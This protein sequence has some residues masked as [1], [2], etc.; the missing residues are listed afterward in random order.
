MDMPPEAVHIDLTNDQQDDV[1][2]TEGISAE[3]GE[4]E[5]FEHRQMKQSRRRSPKR[6]RHVI[7]SQDLEETEELEAVLQELEVCHQLQC[8][9]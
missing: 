1:K 7:D 2:S 4:E 3:S 9:D 8:W 6:Q 5:D